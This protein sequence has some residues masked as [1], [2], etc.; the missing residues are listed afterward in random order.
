MEF[1]NEDL[2]SRT[3]LSNGAGIE[4]TTPIITEF[5]DP[6]GNNLG[7]NLDERLKADWGNFY[8]FSQDLAYNFFNTFRI[9]C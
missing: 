2:D 1:P 7:F 3:F 4:S 5:N 6:S 8:V 9:W